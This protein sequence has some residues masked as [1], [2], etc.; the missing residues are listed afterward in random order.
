[1][2]GSRGRAPLRAAAAA[3]VVAALVAG[4]A[5]VT[6]VLSGPEADTVQARFQIRHEPRPSD[7][8]VVAIDDLSFGEL[9]RRWPFPRSLHARAI[10]RLHAAGARE[11]V[12]DV[13]FTEPTVPRE[14]E[15]LYRA[16]ERAGGAVLATSESDASGH[17]NVL[18]GDATLAA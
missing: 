7:V 11:I 12:Y 10:D 13:Q 15:A 2:T 3:A 9:N 18:G 6:G 14:D 5:L 17:T 8:V 4:L 16:I 1:M